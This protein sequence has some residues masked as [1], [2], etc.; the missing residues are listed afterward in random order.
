MHSLAPAY[1]GDG[2]FM[3]STMHSKSARRL[4]IGRLRR[5]L[6]LAGHSKKEFHN[7]THAFSAPAKDETVASVLVSQRMSLIRF[8]SRDSLEA[9]S[10]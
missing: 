4:L 7:N 6:L 5:T 8:Y 3:P 2:N 1:G 10:I 9:V